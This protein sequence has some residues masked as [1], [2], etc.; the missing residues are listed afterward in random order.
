[1]P[2]KATLRFHLTPIRMAKIIIN[3]NKTLI[4]DAGE[5][6]GKRNNHSLLVGMQ[7]VPDTLKVSL[8][9]EKKKVYHMSLR[10]SI[11]WHMA[12]ELDIHSTGSA[13][14]IAALFIMAGKWKQPKCP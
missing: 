6:V 2:N 4:T 10:Y 3:N 9:R 5:V 7:I 11:S 8:E 1:M 14:F 12:K 13:L